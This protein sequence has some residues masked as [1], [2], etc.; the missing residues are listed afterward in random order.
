[1][2]YFSGV[3]ISNHAAVSTTLASPYDTISNSS[4]S[5]STRKVIV[6]SS[7]YALLTTT[8]LTISCGI[9]FHW[10]NN[11]ETKELFQFL[12]PHLK[13]PECR[14]L[15]GRVLKAAVSKKD[16]IMNEELCQD[17][18]GITLT[19][20]SWSNIKAEEIHI[21]VMKKTEEMIH[22]LQSMKIKVSA[23]VTDSAGPYAAA[24]NANNKYFIAKLHNQQKLTYKKYYGIAVLGETRLNSYYTVAITLLRSQQ[25]LKIFAL[26]HQPPFTQTRRRVGENPT[27]NC[28]I[29]EIIDSGTFWTNLA[30]IAEILFAYLVQL[31]NNNTNQPL[32]EKVLTRLEK[33]WN[34]WEQ[35]PLLVYH[36]PKAFN[37]SKLRAEIKW[38]HRQESNSTKL[39]P[40]KITGENDEPSNEIE[41]KS[42]ARHEPESKKIE[43]EVNT[44]TKGFDDEETIELSSLEEF[45]EETKKLTGIDD[46]DEEMSFLSV[47]SVGDIIHP[48]IDSNAK[49]DIIMLFNELPLP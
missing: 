11:P 28:D 10:V 39:P 7:S 26:N 15:G 38:G 24:R 21:E 47:G 29:F 5:S 36:S 6:R 22:E 34:S 20:D 16:K 9:A 25:A 48:A 30:I 8:W 45:A 1:M 12:N 27:I 17:E 19:F 31:W 41:P 4:K 13:L 49:W 14:I 37:M 43:N 44:A 42:E 32:A 2:A 33:R 23:V 18:I 3:R 35:Q 40:P 46:E